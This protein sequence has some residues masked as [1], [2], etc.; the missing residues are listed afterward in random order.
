MSENLS[1]GLHPHPRRFDYLVNLKREILKPLVHKKAEDEP[2]AYATCYWCPSAFDNVWE[3]NLTYWSLISGDG[4]AELARPLIED[5]WW[6]FLF[7][8]SCVIFVMW[9][10][11]NLVVAAVVDMAAR[12]REEDVQIRQWNDSKSQLK[13]WEQISKIVVEMDKDGDGEITADEFVAA[14][15]T[16]FDLQDHVYDM[17]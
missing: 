2:A 9:G 13:A 5:H 17:V 8:L 7:F 11:L 3:A 16:N 10:L 15:E 6:A 14:W 1:R 4:W 12:S